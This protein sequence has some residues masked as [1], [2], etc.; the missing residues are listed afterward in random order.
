MPPH[1]QENDPRAPSFATGG[2][3]QTSAS[4]I[5]PELDDR[6]YLHLRLANGLSALVVSDPS[7]DKA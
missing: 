7:T 5:K 4:I 6:S 1:E 3:V 2:G